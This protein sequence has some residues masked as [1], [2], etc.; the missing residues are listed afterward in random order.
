MNRNKPSQPTIVSRK[1]ARGFQY[2]ERHGLASF[3]D[4]K[5]LIFTV[6]GPKNHKEAQK[7]EFQ[8]FPHKLAV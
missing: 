5:L 8:N 7:F 2:L 1:T 3:S 6:R 4:C